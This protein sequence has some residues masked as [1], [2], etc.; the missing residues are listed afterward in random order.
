MSTF[1]LSATELHWADLKT[2]HIDLRFLGEKIKSQNIPETGQLAPKT[3]RPTKNMQITTRPRFRRQLA[4][5]RNIIN[6]YYYCKLNAQIRH[7]LG[8][9]SKTEDICIVEFYLAKADH[10]KCSVCCHPTDPEKLPLPK[11]FYWSSWKR[12]FLFHVLSF[13]ISSVFPFKNACI[14]LQKCWEC[15]LTNRGATEREMNWN[16]CHSLL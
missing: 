2:H 7:H 12:F 1:N 13:S 15:A 14:S 4:P 8:R 10:K 11:N 3:T 5:L 16:K 6:V 9:L